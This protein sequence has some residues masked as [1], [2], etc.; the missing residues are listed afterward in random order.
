MLEKAREPSELPGRR[1]F[2]NVVSETEI[3]ARP[4]SWGRHLS[5]AQGPLGLGEPCWVW[6]SPAGAG[7]SGVH[8][9]PAVGVTLHLCP[10]G[11]MG[12]G[13]EGPSAAAVELLVTH[14]V[15]S[16]WLSPAHCLEWRPP[17]GASVLCPPHTVGPGHSQIGTRL[18]C[19]LFSRSPLAQC[20]R[21]GDTTAT[22]TPR[23]RVTVLPGSLRASE[24]HLRPGARSPSQH[25]G[26]GAVLGL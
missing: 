4:V 16:W 5:K 11:T 18:P 22:D 12:P 14:A 15:P 21:L 8:I 23:P 26:V 24:G 3:A 17:A 20:H 10:L 9:L 13:R 19:S 2:R 25:R 6:G 7:S 1:T